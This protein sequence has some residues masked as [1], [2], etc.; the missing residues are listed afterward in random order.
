MQAVVVQQSD[1]LTLGGRDG[2]SLAERSQHVWTFQGGPGPS[3]SGVLRVASSL[4]GDKG[5]SPRCS[6]SSKP[7]AHPP[8]PYYPPFRTIGG[9]EGPSPPSP[10]PK[11]VLT[12]PGRK[13]ICITALFSL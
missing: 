13:W 4:Q 6:M 2:S 11:Q 9:Q 3:P 1:Q 5:R 12:W 7:R 8:L 10:F